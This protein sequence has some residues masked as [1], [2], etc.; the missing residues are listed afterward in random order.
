[1]NPRNLPENI[2]FWV[3]VLTWPLYLIGALFLVGPALA[4]ILFAF[5]CASA[6]LG[7]ATR[8]DLRLSSAVPPLVWCWI[9]GVL[10]M[11]IA[12]WVG[13]INWNL[14]LSLTIKSTIGWMKGWALVALFILIGAVLQ[15]RREVL[16]RGQN[17]VGLV[18]LLILPLMLIAPTIGLPSRIF[19][20]PLQATGG[21]GPEYFSVYLYTIDPANGSARWQF[22]APW[23]PFA[24]LLGVTMVIFA[25]EDK[26]KFWLLC[27]LLSG[28]AMIYFSR[29]RMSLVGL[30]VCLVVPRLLSFAKNSH[31]WLILAGL[32]SSLGVYG[33]DALN[34][35]NS[36]I[37]NF[38]GARVSSSRVRDT[39][40]NIGY[41]RWQTEAVW[42]GHGTIE[43]GPHIVEFMPIGSHHTWYALLFVK[44]LVGFFALF[45]PLVWQLVAVTIDAMQSLRGRLPCALMLNLIIL[46]FGENLEVEVYLLWPAYVLLG[47]HAREMYLEKRVG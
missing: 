37:E 10:V 25:I 42:F 29:S 3:F 8:S 13:H 33:S 34:V 24:G 19:V 28:I 31:A 21:P 17:I 12:L 46:T 1:M 35:V 38:K 39:I 47:I 43:R 14:G 44:G 41:H 6:Y 36:L 23:S 26:K 9:A 40:Q 7:P 18:T 2:C 4:W 16:I 20:S 45:V 32:T 15:I 30:A 11:L 5:I 27:G 22:Y